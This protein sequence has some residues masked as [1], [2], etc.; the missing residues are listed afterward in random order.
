MAFIL[1]KRLT[2]IKVHV[3]KSANKREII[4]GNSANNLSSCSFCARQYVK[5]QRTKSS[6]EE[7]KPQKSLVCNRLN[8][9][10]HITA[11]EAKDYKK[12]RKRKTILILFKCN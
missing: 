12:K 3:S 4:L 11:N 6:L 2:K 10:M 7:E 1:K 8:L 9:F 5:H